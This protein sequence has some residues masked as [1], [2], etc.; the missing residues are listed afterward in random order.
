[1]GKNKQDQKQDLKTAKGTRD[2]SD[3]DQNVLKGIL[4]TISRVIR[5]NAGKEL[6]TPVFELE[7]V[8]KGKY[9]EDS[10]L[11]YD[12]KDQGGEALS[13]RYDLTVPF[14]RWLAMNPNISNYKRLAVDKVWRRDQPALA[15]GRLREF[16]QCDLDFAG[17]S[18]PMIADSEIIAIIVEVFE[19]LGWNGRYTVKLNDRR[20]LDGM[21]EVCGVPED[22]LRPISS[23]VDKLDKAPWEEVRREMVETKGLEPEVADK[24]KGYVMLK[25]G[26][27]LVEKLQKDEAL[28]ANPKAKLGIEE[29][30]LLFRYLAA[31]KVVDKVNFDLSLAR[32]LDYYT[33]IIYE[34]RAEESTSFSAFDTPTSNGATSQPEKPKQESKKKEKKPVAE[35][36]DR[37]DDP[38]VT[39]GS[40]A[41]GGRYDNL[42]SRFRPNA[43]VPCV[44]VSF[45]INRIFAITKE[46]IAK[47][48]KFDYITD[49]AMDV[50]V[51]A[52]GS[53][54]TE[55]RIAK[56][57]KP[58]VQYKF[59]ETAGAP[60]GIILGEEEEKN[61]ELRIKR[62]GI[63]DE[64]EKE[65]LG[66][67]A[68]KGIVVKMA[69][70][71]KECRRLLD[72][73]KLE[74]K[75]QSLSLK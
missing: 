56:K 20:V 26:K 61:G 63:Q 70:V 44:G 74:Q 66:E 51:M 6:V 37:S 32:G 12:L 71:G 69:D 46:R 67:L 45:G 39:V 75:T 17:P 7:E 18:D 8:L 58:N 40:V 62:L 28:M 19:T 1:M 48:E 31:W 27:D 72:E 25:G 57:P 10:K 35:D 4:D 11:I 64:K 34:V 3:E 41:A 55:S 22:K 15:K 59:A 33:G 60:L 49:N 30:S 14:A 73:V 36:E 54:M 9:G 38:S 21:F 24:I 68:D 43:N 65:R 23:A 2:W 13:L 29:M 53:D 16:Y 52:F 5:E 42:V 50:Y 47:G